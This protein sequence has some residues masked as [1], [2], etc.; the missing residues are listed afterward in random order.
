MFDNVLLVKPIT[1]FNATQCY[2]QQTAVVST[3]DCSG[4]YNRLQCSVQKTAVLNTRDCNVKYNRL[5]S[6]VFH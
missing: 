1:M 4:K 3:T 5:V 6:C 2:A